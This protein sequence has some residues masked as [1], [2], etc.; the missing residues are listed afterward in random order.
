MEI[1]FDRIFQRALD[2]LARR[3]NVPVVVDSKAKSSNTDPKKMYFKD[4]TQEEL[5]I[6]SVPTQAT[7]EEDN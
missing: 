1:D 3:A 6:G 5:T 4:L 7:E 2:N